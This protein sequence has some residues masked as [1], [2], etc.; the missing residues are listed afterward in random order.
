VTILIT[1]CTGLLGPALVRRLA[2]QAEVVGTSRHPAVLPGARHVVCDLTDADAVARLIEAVAPEAVIHAQA[3]SD[4]DVCEQQPELADRQ[5]VQTAEHLCR[6]LAQRDAVV[7]GISTDY[8]FDGAKGRPYDEQDACRPLNVYGRT[9]VAVEALVRELPRGIV[10]RVSTL[11]GPDRLNFCGFAA[12]RLAAGA[13][14]EAFSDQVT[15]PTYTVDLADGLAALIQAAQQRRGSVLP[16]TVHVV[17]QGSCGRVELARTVAELVGAPLEL[18]R[19]VPMAAQRRP[20]PRP[21]YSALADTQFRTLV[22]RSLRG[23]Q[24]ALCEYLRAHPHWRASASASAPS[25]PAS[26]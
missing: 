18:V 25:A 13:P 12:A 5:N 14:V 8:V 19:P 11:F 10:A 7:I 17:N 6:A 26:A 23:W 16:G 21:P 1:G 20:A 15:S 3:Q 9:K 4:V 24:D 2:P 22:G